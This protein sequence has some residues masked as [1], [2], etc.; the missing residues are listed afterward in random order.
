[1]RFSVNIPNFG[2]FA[3]A[4]AVATVA[5]RAEQ[6]GW[7]ALL[8]WDH[9]VHDKQQR[10]G[11]PFGDPW[12]LLTAA[13]LATTTLRLGTLVT[14]VARRRPE[15]LA[16]QV[17]TLDSLSGGRVIFGAGLGGPI[18]D[19]FASFGEPTDPVV[20][21]EHLDE[22]LELLHRYWSGE[23][24]N[25]HGRHYQVRD[26]TLLP[27]SVQRPRPPVWIG[28]FWPRRRPMRRAARWDGAVPLF[29]DAKHGHAPPVDQLRDL[30]SFVHQNREDRSDEP[31]EIVV[32]GV[33]PGD[34]AR[35]R[36]LI[37][38]LA[39]AGA[40]WWD[41]RQIETS[42]DLDRLTPVLRRVDQGPPA[43]T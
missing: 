4:G 37:E 27:A 12:M 30:V 36:D 21:A 33:S 34:P 8:I 38:P 18:E 24:V 9:V 1:M 3:D 5:T 14:P 41:E 17:A 43:L 11:Q 35:A 6:A 29:A 26:V 20:L 19:E 32:G 23:T 10:R 31:F 42:E 28:G 16:R 22:G 7:D 2:D 25:H 40:T 15:Q 13:A 39:A